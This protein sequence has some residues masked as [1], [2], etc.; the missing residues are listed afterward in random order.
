MDT[1]SKEQLDLHWDVIPKP[2]K[3]ALDFLSAQDWLCRFGWYLSDPP[4]MLHFD[5]S[6]EHV[7]KF[8]Y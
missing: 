8:F 4:L 2:T 6:W 7:K 1:S 5:A 3:K